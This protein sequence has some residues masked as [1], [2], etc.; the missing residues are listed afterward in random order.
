MT[1]REHFL[2]EFLEIEQDRKLHEE[3]LNQVK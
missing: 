3:I 2:E 1:E